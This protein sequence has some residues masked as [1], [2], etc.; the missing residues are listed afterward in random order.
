[1]DKLFAGTSDGN[2]WRRDPTSGWTNITAGLPERYVT[3]VHGSPTLPTRIF[4]THSGFRDNEYIPHVHRSDNNGQN[5]NDISGDLPQIPVND[6][7]VLPNHAD[8][9][10]FAATDVGVYF[11][12][13]AGQN[14]SR[15]GGNMPFVPTFDLEHNPVRKEIVAATYARGIWTFPLDSVF[16]Q[17]NAVTVNVGG[18]IKT[19]GQMGVPHVEIGGQQSGLAGDF[20]IAGVPGC[21][22]YTLAPYRNDNPLNG[23][24]TYDLVLI[25][26]HILN[27]EPLNSPYKIIAADANKNNAVTT[28]DIVTIRRL[29]LGIDTVFSS[30]TSWRFIPKAYSFPNPLNPFQ[31]LFPETLDISLQNLSVSEQ[32]FVA[33]KVGDVNSNVNPV[34]ETLAEERVSDEWPIFLQNVGFEKDETVTAEFQAN[35]TGVEALQFSINFDREKLEFEKI[36]PLLP[37]LLPEHFGTNRAGSGV[38]TFSFEQILD[39]HIFYKKEQALFR[40]V[41]KAKSEG[42]LAESLGLG[43]SPTP[44]LAYQLGGEPV[45]PVLGLRT[46]PIMPSTVRVGPNPFGQSGLWLYFPSPSAGVTISRAAIDS[47]KIQIFDNLGKMIFQKQV[48]GE[49]TEFLPANIFP[50]QGTYFYKISGGTNQVGKLVFA[51]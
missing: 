28:T 15:L 12:L 5:W 46:L 19:E 51:F 42:D 1:M 47:T 26:K 37:G 23:V 21:Q 38:L 6:L 44:A 16:A 34:A 14:W 10:L 29:I 48:S 39:R 4:T 50:A 24:S 40:V 32:D 43:E 22:N 11:T 8:S 27:L 17:Q 36:E 7:F 9:V 13:N 49:K 31:P 33:V 35:L 3:S 30:N 2:V 41:F 20:S 25:S 45:K 18:S